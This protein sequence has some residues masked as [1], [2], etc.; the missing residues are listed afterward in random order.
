MRQ[1]PD[2][3]NHLL[4]GQR[5]RRHCGTACDRPVEI[6][7]PLRTVTHGGATTYH[8][9]QYGSRVPFFTSPVCRSIPMVLCLSFCVSYCIY[10]GFPVTSNVCLSQCFLIGQVLPGLYVGSYRDSKDLHQLS[11]NS[12]THIV[13]VHD[14]AKKWYK[15][16]IFTA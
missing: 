3:Y 11:A 7:A 15:V 12:I 4:A 14:T 2:S 9:G 6:P 5:L 10:R 13:A 16:S 1:A 8:V